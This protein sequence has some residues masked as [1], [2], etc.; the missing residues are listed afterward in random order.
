MFELWEIS[1]HGIDIVLLE[2]C[3]QISAPEGLTHCGLVTPYGY[4][5]LGQHW[6]RQW[7]V[8]WG[9]Q[10]ITWTYVDFSWLKSSDIHIRAISQE[11]P[12]PSITNVHLKITYLKFYWNS[13]GANEL[14]L[15]YKGLQNILCNLVHY[16]VCW[17]Y[18]SNWENLT[19]SESKLLCPIPEAQIR[20]LKAK[21]RV[22]QEEMDKLADDCHKKVW[23]SCL[24]KIHETLKKLADI[25]Q[26]TF[27]VVCSQREMFVS[28]FK[29]HWFIFKS[30]LVQAMV[31]YQ[32]G[33]KAWL[34]EPVMTD[35]KMKI[36]LSYQQFCFIVPGH[37]NNQ[38]FQQGQRVRGRTSSVGTH[39][40]SASDT[41]G[42]IPQNGRR[43]SC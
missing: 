34:P 37:R 9:Y 25:L 23:S 27:S 40:G 18:L 4:R 19:Y 33:N 38:V 42:E 41:N 8:A 22:M 32:T 43:W 13:P 20:F 2:Y 31:W 30:I 15:S 36:V 6:L 3:I 28:W 12:Q 35:R 5:D 39:R 17:C 11:M 1:D 14:N 24:L 29:F 16:H 21:L 10:A 26:T 7:L